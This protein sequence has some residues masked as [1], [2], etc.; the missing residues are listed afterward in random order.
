MMIQELWVC[1]TGAIIGFVIGGA[2]GMLIMGCAN[3]ARQGDLEKK[4]WARGISLDHLLS[5]IE[6]EN[7]GGE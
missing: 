6:S 5:E 2:L 4:L 3:S 1:G 7:R